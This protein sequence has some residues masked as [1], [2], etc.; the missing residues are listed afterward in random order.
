MPKVEDPDASRPMSCRPAFDSCDRNPFAASVLHCC[1]S[2]R[3]AGKNP[4]SPTNVAREMGISRG[5]VCKAKGK[6]GEPGKAAQGP[7]EI[8]EDPVSQASRTPRFVRLVF[9]KMSVYAASG[10]LALQD[11][12]LRVVAAIAALRT[13]VSVS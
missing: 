1:A 13:E 4:R 6:A 5:T 10:R 11:V 9:F 8:R 3:N 2:N 12:R 7:L